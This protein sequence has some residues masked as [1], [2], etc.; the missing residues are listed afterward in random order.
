LRSFFPLAPA[1]PGRLVRLVPDVV[2]NGSLGHILRARLSDS[3]GSTATKSRPVVPGGASIKT[4]PSFLVPFEYTMVRSAAPREPVPTVSIWTS[5]S[6]LLPNPED[7]V[8]R[9]SQN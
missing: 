2:L 8:Q 4:K 3:K 9:S 5:E 6:P 7:S 1:P